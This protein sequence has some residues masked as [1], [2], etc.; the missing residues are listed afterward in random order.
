MQHGAGDFSS[1]R[2]PSLRGEHKLSHTRAS[3]FN[4]ECHSH[5]RKNSKHGRA[6]SRTL[7]A[8]WYI[9]S[10]SFLRGSNSTRSVSRFFVTTCHFTLTLTVTTGSRPRLWK[11]DAHGARH[12]QDANKAEL[13]RGK[14]YE[15][16][17]AVRRWREATECCMQYPCH[18]CPHWL[19]PLLVTG[20]PRWC[21]RHSRSPRLSYRGSK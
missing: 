13:D 2:R 12:I 7:Y 18:I 10:R 19:T 20:L 21:A 14:R 1:R 11:L 3:A 17:L 8:H 16:V 4:W 9:T 6:P 15:M 5:R